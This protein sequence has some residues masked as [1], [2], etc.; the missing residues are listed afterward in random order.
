[1]RGR[2]L[3]FLTVAASWPAG[4]NAQRL[5]Y[6]DVL[7]AEHA[8]GP[9][10]TYQP[11]DTGDAVIAAAPRPRPGRGR[12]RPGPRRLFR[13]DRIS[14]PARR[15]RLELGPFGRVRQPGDTASGWRPPATPRCAARSNMSRARRSTAI[16]S[17]T[18]A[19]PCRPASGRIS[20]ARAA[21][22]RCSALQG[23]VTAPLYVGLFGYP[24]HPAR[25]HRPRLRLL[26]LGAGAAAGA[27]ALCRAARRRPATFR[28]SASAM[29]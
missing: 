25:G 9:R 6:H 16:R 11:I 27:P 1:M 28:R 8:V 29:A 20:S 15:R 2:F 18:P 4:A 12:G 13:P 21:P 14:R 26:R 22:M 7:R 10:L 3:L 19:S 24:L 23:N 17:S 5:A